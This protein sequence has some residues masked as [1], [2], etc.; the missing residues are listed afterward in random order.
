ML[1]HIPEP[2]MH[3][4][5]W[6]LTIGWLTLIAS[7]FYDPI[8]IR[9]TDPNDPAS[10][11]SAFR[12]KPEVFLNPE[13]CVKIQEQCIHEQ[14]FAMGAIIFWAMIVPA[15][16]AIIFVFGHEFWRRICP[17]S[18]LSQIPRALGIQRRRTRF[19]E[20]S[21]ET[22]VETVK[23]DPDS[24]LGKNYLYVQSGLFV[25][26]LWARLVF[27]NG[28]RTALGLFLIATIACAIFVG[29]LYDGKSWCQYFCPMA[30][31]QIIYT[32][33]RSLMGSRAHLQPKPSIS[34]S[35]CRIVDSQTGQEV[36]AC[37][38]CKRPACFDIDAEQ[39]YWKELDRPGR[40]L[41]HYG[42]WGMVI[43]FYLYFF[44]YA[45][46]WDYYFSGSWAHEET[47]LS[48][49]NA[50]GFYVYHTKIGIPKWIAVF[51]TFGVFIAVF[52]AIGCIAE[53]LYRRLM[54]TLIARK[55][56]RFPN[57]RQWISVSAQQAR[58]SMYSLFTF[59][60]FWTFFSFG[61][62]PSLNRLPP[63]LISG[64]NLFVI[65]T[66]GIWIYRTLSRSQRQYEREQ[67]ST[68]LR[69]QLQQL[70][71]PDT[72]LQGRTLQQLKPDEVYV[73]AKTLPEFSQQQRQQAYTGILK[74]LLESNVIDVSSSFEFLESLR[75]ELD[76]ED[77]DHWNA[78][79]VITSIEPELVQ[80]L[81][82]STPTSPR[83]S[84]QTQIYSRSRTEASQIHDLTL[85]IHPWNEQKT[86]P[87]CNDIEQ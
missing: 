64:C 39:T 12:L 65:V 80:T 16:I 63:L 42:Y 81:A 54:N 47:L 28:D 5:R 62:R 79:Q 87:I 29:Y 58:H 38:N 11:G 21:G 70:E 72:V 37:V 61:A 43:A 7:L 46:N 50:P 26:G 73:L 45:G 22:L 31:V 34:Q 75:Q 14:P 55:N 86:V 20:R 76:L 27:V 49:I 77:E 18:F 68:S 19:D 2:I 83:G 13:R 53:K 44:L 32:G 33:P 1:H 4:A 6:A 85:P 9:W 52:Y 82:T 84:E 23:V 8:T 67:I 15:G 71:I 40:R 69:R 48:T 74:E 35:I 17:L 60:A 10:I 3:R 30:P 36:S 66:G 24:W 78:I 25:L 51:I 59:V 41:W 57:G 56:Q